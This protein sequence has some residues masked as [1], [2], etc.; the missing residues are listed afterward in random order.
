VNTPAE[1]PVLIVDDQPAVV[2]SLEVLL[3]LHEIANLSATSPEVALQIAE[4][5]TLGAV[6]QDMNFGRSETSGTQGIELFRALREA[7]PGVPILLMTAWASL[8]TAV[9]L[10]KEGASD[11]IAK[12]WD[13][14]KLLAG[15]RNLLQLRSLQLENERLTAEI[16]DSRRGL[17]QQ[18]D[19]CGIIYESRALHRA[20]S[21]AVNIAGSDAPVLITGPSGSGKE[22][23]AEI[24]Q[25]NSLRRQGPFLRVN[26]GAI[27]EELMESELF[28]AEAG[29]YTGSEKRRI[30][31]FESA[32]GGTLF[33]DE[34]DALSLSGQV[35]LLRVLQSGD[36]QRLGSS[37]TLHSDVRV[38]SATNAD[39]SESIS[40]GSFR[41]DLF[42]RLNVVELKVPGLLDRPEDVLPLAEFFL[43]QYTDA[44]DSLRLTFSDKARVAL[45]EHDWPGNVREL[46]NRVHR[47]TLVASGDRVTPA[48][49]GLATEPE[50]PEL[51]SPPSSMA[52]EEI[53]EHKRVMQALSEAQGVVAHAATLL[54]ISRQALY[55]KMDRLGIELERRPKGGANG[56]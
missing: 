43:T 35:K 29:A 30:G 33:L 34:I 42:F 8:E 37:R 1:L 12:P 25:A 18:Y 56:L 52:A 48:D 23:L 17:D 40:A 32:N 44:G 46:E 49:L 14:E 26:V 15:L 19:L 11:Y 51:E 28:G 3:D 7:Q 55:R 4:G 47:G 13:D 36:F 41:E 50:P 39:L 45:V 9:Q 21:L 24:I 54:G 16:R 53:A 10:V 2:K 22:R 27:P 6:L 31:H 38:V 20:I 5:Q